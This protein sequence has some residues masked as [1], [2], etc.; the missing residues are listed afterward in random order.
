MPEE[1][2]HA[3]LDYLSEKNNII[4]SSKKLLKRINTHITGSHLIE[5]GCATG[6]FLQTARNLG[7]QTKGFEISSYA[8]SMARKLFNLDVECCDFLNAYDLNTKDTDVVVALDVIEHLR[9]PAKFLEKCNTILRK[10]GLL[11]ISTGDFSS[12]PAKISGRR[13][14]LI[15][16][17]EHIYYFTR[18]GLTQLLVNSGFEVLDIK[19]LWKRYSI[20]FVFTSLGFGLFGSLGN[21]SIPFNGFDVMYIFARKK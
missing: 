2:Q 7:W 17:P 6:F 10:N 3:Y 11:L 14:R 20:R 18:V 13:W 15:H 1:Q 5:V 21:V 4:A 12:I 9:D 16:P 8:A 19:Y